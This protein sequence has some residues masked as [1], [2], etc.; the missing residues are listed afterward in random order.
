MHASSFLLSIET[1]CYILHIDT[2]RHFLQNKSE[3]KFGGSGSVWRSG[4][5][6]LIFVIT[7]T[8]SVFSIWY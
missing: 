4:G 8:L 7:N 1:V 3:K 2:N 5:S 6:R